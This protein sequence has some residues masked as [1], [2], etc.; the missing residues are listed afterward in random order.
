MADDLAAQLTY[1]LHHRP[2]GS[3]AL[4]ADTVGGA[5][6]PLSRDPAGLP[7]GVVAQH[8]ALA[9]ADALTLTK[10]ASR[11]AAAVAGSAELAVAAYDG[12]GRLVDATRVT[13]A[14]WPGRR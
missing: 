14:A 3:L 5:S 2:A 4:D 12:L 6:L 9:D 1:R 7:A 13:V 10:K 8:P 11:D